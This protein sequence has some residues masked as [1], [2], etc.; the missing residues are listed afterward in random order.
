MARA[1]NVVGQDGRGLEPAAGYIAR[2]EA[3]TV[4]FACARKNPTPPG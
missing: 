3:A 4:V 2:L 1:A